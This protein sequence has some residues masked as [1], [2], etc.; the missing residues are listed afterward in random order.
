MREEEAAILKQKRHILKNRGHANRQR[1]NKKE[2][3]EVTTTEKIHLEVRIEHGKYQKF[4]ENNFL[5]G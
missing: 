2:D 1:D 5:K 3:F 4:Y